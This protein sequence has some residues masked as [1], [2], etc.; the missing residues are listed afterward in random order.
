MLTAVNLLYL[1]QSMLAA[2]LSI[3]SLT[4]TA[5]PHYP[6][7]KRQTN[8]DDGGNPDVGTGPVRPGKNN[9]PVY[10]GGTGF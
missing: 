8:I 3:D 5:A 9:K 4:P 2:A 1:S 10:P 6:A 7:M